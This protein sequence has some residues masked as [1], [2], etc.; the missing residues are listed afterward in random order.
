[1]Q[2]V[3]QLLAQLT[4]GEHLQLANALGTGVH[5]SV[6]AAECLTVP[7]GQHTEPTAQLLACL[8][9]AIDELDTA[10]AIVRSHSYWLET[11]LRPGTLPGRCHWMGGA[12]PS[13]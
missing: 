10:R 6:L 4:E 3:A 9:Q 1:M 2:T 13:R 11:Q 7:R 8:T 5:A 12:A